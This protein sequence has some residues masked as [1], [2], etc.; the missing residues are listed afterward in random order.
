MCDVVSY[1]G[2]TTSTLK[3]K[4]P[5]FSTLSTDKSGIRNSFLD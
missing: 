3:T 5:V 1:Y 4:T 2:T